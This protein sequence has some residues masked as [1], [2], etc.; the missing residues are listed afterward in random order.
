MRSD[1]DLFM[2]DTACW[3]NPWKLTDLLYIK[4]ISAD[5]Q[6]SSMDVQRASLDV[7]SSSLDVQ[8]ASLDVQLVSTAVSY[9]CSGATQRS[10][11]LI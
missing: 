2:R 6:G 3:L 7:Q 11:K 8:R 9:N 4:D 5:V 10:H 1:L